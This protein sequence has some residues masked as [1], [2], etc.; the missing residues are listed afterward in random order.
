MPV[1]VK[2]DYV[3]INYIFIPVF[4]LFL[5]FSFLNCENEAAEEIDRNAVERTTGEIGIIL[6]ENTVMRL[7]PMIYSAVVTYLSK[8]EKVKIIK[9]SSTKSWIGNDSDYWYMTRYSKGF[10]GWIYGRNMKIFAEDETGKIKKYLS[11][12]WQKEMAKTRSMLKGLWKSIRIDSSDPEQ[13]L[14]VY[15]DGN[16]ISYLSDEKIIKG[17]YRL[18]Y[19]ESEIVFS[20]GTYFGKK[21]KYTTRE[22]RLYLIVK[23]GNKDLQFKKLTRKIENLDPEKKTEDQTA[24]QSENQSEDN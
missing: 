14:I 3:K 21:I 2:T 17:Q 5:F 6:T 9:K 18:N 4:L 1:K 19:K 7:D 23:N 15:D 11:K 24:D 13:N 10:L 22:R 8:G 12:F 20:N 16:Y